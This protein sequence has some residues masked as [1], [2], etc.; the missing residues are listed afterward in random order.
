[1]QCFK[2]VDFFEEKLGSS[3]IQVGGLFK[4]NSHINRKL[5]VQ[6]YIK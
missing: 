3:M 1:M 2:C 4:K 5:K 6:C